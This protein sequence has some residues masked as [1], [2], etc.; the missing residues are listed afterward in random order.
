[1]RV[2]DGLVQRLGASADDDG[3]PALPRA[4]QRDGAPDA[5]AASGDDD[6]AVHGHNC[7]YCTSVQRRRCDAFA[8]AS[9]TACTITPSRNDG[10]QGRLPRIASM[11]STS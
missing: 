6:D 9:M 1:M 11:N 2:L 5:G 4:L 7:G 3:G 10:T 8:A